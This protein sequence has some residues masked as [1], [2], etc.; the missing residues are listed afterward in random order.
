VFVSATGGIGLRT[1]TLHL[2]DSLAS[3]IRRVLAGQIHAS[4]VLPPARH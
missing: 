3:R 2:A 1:R 4:P